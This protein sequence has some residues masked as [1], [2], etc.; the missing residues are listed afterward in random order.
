MV[1]RVTSRMPSVFIASS[2]EGLPVARALQQQLEDC[3]D[4]RRWDEIGVPGSNFLDR[5]MEVIG[6]VDMGLFVL[7]DDDIVIRRRK[8]MPAPRDNVILEFGFS[9]ATL[10]RSRSLMV[11]PDIPNL[12]LPEDVKGIHRVLYHDAANLGSACGKIR[13]ALG[14]INL[15]E[16]DWAVVDPN[17]WSMTFPSPSPL[18]RLF[19]KTTSDSLADLL[20]RLKGA[21]RHFT[22]FGLTRGFYVREEIRQLIVEK[23]KSIPI[24]L[25]LMDPD[26]G[27]R[28][29]RYR[30]EPSHAAME[31]P[32][33][34]KREI[35][36]RYARMQQDAGPLT[37][38]RGLGIWTFDFPCSYAMEHIDD[39]CR[40]M[41]YGHG[42]RGTEGPIMVFR[43]G[44]PYYESFVRQLEWLKGLAS[45]KVNGVWAMNKRL[46]V[47]PCK[48]HEAL[49][50]T[51]T[52]RVTGDLGK[53]KRPKNRRPR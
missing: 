13:F 33:R 29:D 1:A 37:E 41:L 22:S 5:L 27:S 30:I 52:N 14:K 11:T 20:N 19:L 6:G 3:A 34:Y 18:E 36:S 9:L 25:F 38:K 39:S 45:G 4:V 51:T 44:T 2:V 15:R 53:Q 49:S 50:M 48:T 35:M 8:K 24:Q 21:R 47:Q 32:E 7:T 23:A 31:D 16:N 46:H 10:G 43:Y 26:C 40:V 28:S 12:C 17:E 42:I